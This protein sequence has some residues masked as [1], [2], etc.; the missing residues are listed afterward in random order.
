MMY[1][2]LGYC[3]LKAWVCNS[4]A[5]EAKTKDVDA[6]ARRNIWY[7]SYSITTQNR[8]IRRRNSRT[9]EAKGPVIKTFG[10]E[11]AGGEVVPQIDNPIAALK[12]EFPVSYN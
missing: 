5:Y 3:F 1:G 11:A 6:Q 9:C 2:S 10:S 7:K 12:L 8:S 4:E